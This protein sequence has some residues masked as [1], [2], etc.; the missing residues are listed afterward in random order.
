MWHSVCHIP[1][2]TW[3]TSRHIPAQT[4][5]PAAHACSPLSGATKSNHLR[6]KSLLTHARQCAHEPSALLGHEPSPLKYRIGSNG[7]SHWFL[8]LLRVASSVHPVIWVLGVL[9]CSLAFRQ[10]GLG[11]YVSGSRASLRQW[12]GCCLA[13]FVWA[14]MLV[15]PCRLSG[16]L[17]PLLAA[18][19]LSPNFFGEAAQQRA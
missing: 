6:F 18:G 10:G 8:C 12:G 15:I 2:A 16:H 3:H 14:T 7:P 1:S 11:S 19:P 9:L 4:C 17:L 5:A 13:S